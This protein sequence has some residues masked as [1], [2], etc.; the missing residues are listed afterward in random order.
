[1]TWT[2]VRKMLVVRSSQ[3]NRAYRNDWL[4][5][6]EYAEEIGVQPWIVYNIPVSRLREITRAAKVAMSQHDAE[7][8]GLLL[9][10]ALRYPLRE[11]KIRLRGHERSIVRMKVLQSG[12]RGKYVLEVTE[13]Q[14][15]QIESSNCTRMVFQEVA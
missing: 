11:L 2:D 14:L 6:L 7:R 10:W 15:R 5:L 9:D 3:T 13:A 12:G 8:F 4:Q 1:M